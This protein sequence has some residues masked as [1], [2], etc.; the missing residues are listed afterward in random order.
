MPVL[1]A[2]THLRVRSCSRREGWAQTTVVA[3]ERTAEGSRRTAVGVIRRIAAAA[4]AGEEDRDRW[5]DGARE[6]CDWKIR[7]YQNLILKGSG[8]THDL[9]YTHLSV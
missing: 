3:A 5:T 6:G 9:Q 2:R 7:C 1:V 4:A 8:A